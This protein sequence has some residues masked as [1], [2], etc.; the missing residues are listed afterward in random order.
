MPW[1]LGFGSGTG[2]WQLVCPSAPEESLSAAAALL[3]PGA[4]NH[5]CV[6]SMDFHVTFSCTWM[7]LSPS[8][9]I[10]MVIAPPENP[11]QQV[12]PPEP[13]ATAVPE[14]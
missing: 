1:R 9:N 13:K 8:E 10:P 2:C 6:Y 14:S 11:P 12:K 5:C 3:H 7:N 4:C